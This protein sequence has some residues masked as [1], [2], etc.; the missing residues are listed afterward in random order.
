MHGFLTNLR[1]VLAY[2]LRCVRAI[3]LANPEAPVGC[4]HARNNRCG[5]IERLQLDVKGRS[6]ER[7][8]L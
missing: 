4:C 1:V 6:R 7:R 3:V 2:R 8:R 5:A